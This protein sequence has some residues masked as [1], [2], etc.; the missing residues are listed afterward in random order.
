MAKKTSMNIQ[1][2]TADQIQKLN[3]LRRGRPQSAPQRREHV[4]FKD[5]VSVVARNLVPIL[6]SVLIAFILAAVYYKATSATYRAQ[7][8]LLLDP[9]LPQVFRELSDFSQNV[10]TTQIET[11]MVAL[12]S[13]ATTAGVVDRLELWNDPA[14]R[15]N[16]RG[17]ILGFRF[18]RPEQDDPREYAID[19]LQRRMAVERVGIS[20]VINISFFSY[21]AARAAIIVNEITRSYI[22]SLIDVR[23]DTARAASEW[24]EDRLEQLRLQMNSAAERAQKFRANEESASLEELQLT[25]EAYRKAYQNFFSAFTEAVQRESYPVSNI[26][27]ISPAVSPRERHSPKALFVF[28]F[29]I[30]LGSAAGLFLAI[31]RENLPGR[32]AR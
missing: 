7:A 9:K 12:K 17:G 26:R 2:S 29:A 30:V 8:Q 15:D 14:F 16:P 6:L 13:R 3:E 11:H 27:V 19:M 31:A 10:D 5:V 24:L 25:A 21:D 28:G 18:S 4:G 22:Q 32:T 1:D 20:Q 23:A